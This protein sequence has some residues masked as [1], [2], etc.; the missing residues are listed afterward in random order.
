MNARLFNACLLLGW[1]LV[2]AGGCLVNVGYG[3][4]FAGLLLLVMVFIVARVAGVYV[5]ERK[6]DEGP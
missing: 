4:V 1:L 3:L 6:D 5:P 2:I